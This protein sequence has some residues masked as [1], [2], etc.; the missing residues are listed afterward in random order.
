MLHL[1][2]GT[3]EHF[4]SV[5]SRHWPELVSRYEQAYRARPYLPSSLGE[6]TMNAVTR[7]RIAHGVSD[8]RL[9][10]LKPPPEPEQL[11]LLNG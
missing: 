3:R 11:T 5:L 9:V 2:D 10:I 1:K 4:M 8:R 6:A 7:L